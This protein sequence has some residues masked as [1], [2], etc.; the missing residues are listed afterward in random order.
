MLS[1]QEQQQNQQKQSECKY[2]GDLQERL[3]NAHL[4]AAVR[5]RF[6]GRLCLRGL[7]LLRRVGGQRLVFLPHR[8]SIQSGGQPH[9]N[10]ADAVLV[11]LRPAG[12]VPPRQFHR[13]VRC[14][15]GDVTL[16]ISGGNTEMAQCQ[17]SGSG[18]IRI[19]A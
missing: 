10:P 11:D 17:N 4:I 13:S 3:C 2:D 8:F 18:I 1:P 12:G 15:R 5:L 6:L 19:M 14:L 9:G 7:G 16:G